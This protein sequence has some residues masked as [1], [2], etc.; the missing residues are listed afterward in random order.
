M[1]HP[2]RST[3]YPHPCPQARKEARKA[4]EIR[5]RE[6]ELLEARK[7]YF[8]ERRTAEVKAKQIFH[9]SAGGVTTGG[10]RVKAKQIFHGSAGS[11]TTG[12]GKVVVGGKDC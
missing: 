4:E 3:P 6:A 7:T 12:G 11:V 2:F 8:E 1:F 9:G 10:G 5:Q